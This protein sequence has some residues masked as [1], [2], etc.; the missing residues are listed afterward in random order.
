MRAKA[1]AGGAK[2]GDAVYPEASERVSLAALRYQDQRVIE[3][4]DREG[5]DL[6]VGRS[7]FLVGVANGQDVFL[8]AG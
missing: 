2:V 4:E 7:P 6:P 5:P 3:I 8:P 1:A